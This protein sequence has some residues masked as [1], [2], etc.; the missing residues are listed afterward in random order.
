MDV[1]PI[2]SNDLVTI[3]AEIE[4]DTNNNYTTNNNNNTMTTLMSQAQQAAEY[5]PDF[6]ESW[7]PE[8][9]D[10]DDDDDETSGLLC[11][12]Q[13][14]DGS[15]TSAAAAATSSLARRMSSF[16]PSER[17]LL[18]RY[19]SLELLVPAH[20]CESRKSSP[21]IAI[22]NLVATVCGGGV[23]SLPLAFA[24]AG[25]V[26]ALAL[27]G[28]AA[29]ITHFS[30]YI[31]CSCARRTG[32]RSYGDV[33]RNAYGPMAEIGATVLLF[34]LLFL[35]LV[36]YMVLLKDI[37]TPVI[38][39]L[40]PV[41][42]QFVASRM[43]ATIT[44]EEYDEALEAKASDYLLV[45]M[46]LCTVPLLLQTDLHALR[47]TCYIGFLSAI[48]LTLGVVNQAY[49]K[50]LSGKLFEN[51]VWVGDVDGILFAFPIIVLSFFSIYNVLT[52]HGALF[53]PTRSRVRIVLDGTIVVC[54]V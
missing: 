27:M 5:E 4:S 34:F 24:K 46:A 48:I 39:K 10:D 43:E 33:M 29:L 23:L 20:D 21:V 52:V 28:F 18:K 15:P 42:Q 11:E 14:S 9:E 37:W 22:F 35:I 19:P 1:V 45:V 38:L 7:N 6:D 53:N 8:E 36:A 44:P 31:L 32:G 2:V 17:E 30:M 40:V 50:N 16:W 41:L 47:H 3:M 12:P 51:I 49:E 13:G 26:P 54:F 25:I